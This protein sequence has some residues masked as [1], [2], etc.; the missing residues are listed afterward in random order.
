[1]ITS[2]VLG[3]VVL[4]ERPLPA[5]FTYRHVGPFSTAEDGFTWIDEHPDDD[6]IRFVLH[7]SIVERAQ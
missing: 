1:M 5:P 3:Y 7:V 2:S 6:E 4:V